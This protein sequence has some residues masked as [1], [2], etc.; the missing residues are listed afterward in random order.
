M[1]LI[2]GVKEGRSLPALELLQRL[3]VVSHGRTVDEFERTGRAE[4]RHVDRHLVHEVRPGPTSPLCEGI[5]YWEIAISTFVQSK[6][7]AFLMIMIA[8]SVC[9]FS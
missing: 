3:R 9:V 8:P 1:R 4:E 2:V 6:L 7:A 5:G